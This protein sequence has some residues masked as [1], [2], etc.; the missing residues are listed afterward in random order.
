MDHFMTWRYRDATDFTAGSKFLREEAV[1]YAGAKVDCYVLTAAQRRGGVTYTWWVDK[2]NFRILR[3]DSPGSSVMFK[4]VKLDEP[5][6]DS[7]FKFVPPPG[8]RKIEN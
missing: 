3:E 4:S 1:E 7:L 5:L 2:Q 6:P 8:A